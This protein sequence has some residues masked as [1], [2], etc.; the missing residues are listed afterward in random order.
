[1]E[2]HRECFDDNY[3]H[4]NWKIRLTKPRSINIFLLDGDPAYPS[5]VTALPG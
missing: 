4:L 5:G 2:N 3:S 1:V